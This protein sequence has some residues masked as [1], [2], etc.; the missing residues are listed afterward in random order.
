MDVLKNIPAK[1]WH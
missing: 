1:W